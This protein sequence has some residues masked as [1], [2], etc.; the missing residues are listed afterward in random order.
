V[1]ADGFIGTDRNGSVGLGN[2]LS[3]VLILNSSGNA[4]IGSVVSSNGP[5]D[6]RG[7]VRIDGLG[8]VA[9]QLTGN[10]VGTNLAGSRSLDPN[11]GGVRPRDPEFPADGTPSAGERNTFDPRNDGVVIAGG[12]SGN[13]I[14]GLG[15]D[16]GNQISGNRI[17]VYVLQS[18]A[19]N[20]LVANR[21]GTDASGTS[22]V[23]NGDGVIV[24]NSSGN[25]IGGLDPAARNVIS[26]N[27]E[28]GVRLTSLAF[29][30][31][32]APASGNVVAGNYIGTNA[33][34]NAS[35]PNRQGVFVYGAADNRIGLGTFADP[36][37]GGNLLSG[38]FEVGIQILNADTINA[39]TVDTDAGPRILPNPAAE[40]A[41]TSGNIV[42]G[43]RIGSDATGT[44]RV[45]NYQGVFLSDAP[46][47]SVVDNLIGGN[48]QVG[49]NITAF[50][51]VNN[52]IGGNRIG[53][54][55]SGNIGP[56]ANGFGDPNGLGTGLLLNQV[57]DGANPIAST[58]DLRGNITAQTRIRPIADGPFVE[59]VI[60]IID[61]TTG[62]LT[63]VDVRINGY[64][65]RDA[66]I[67]LN[68]NNA[69]IE[70]IGLGP[71]SLASVSYDE[72]ARLLS[73]TP[74]SPLAPGLSFRLT[75][76]GQ[77]PG[78]LRSRPG[79]GIAP[80]F[81]DGTGN[82]RPGSNFVE[83][84]TVPPRAGTSS[85]ALIARAV[86]ALLDLD[87]LA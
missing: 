7:N 43:N 12:A 72:V 22:G 15:Q 37:G 40:G 13:S 60:P 86:D 3:G 54:D 78:G 77:R 26:G 5:S 23:S 70:P 44:D 19:G 66:A 53:P 21:I 29:E 74:S 9:N 38:N 46:G 50:N 81:L 28:T 71:V 16:E 69:I 20:V 83:V 11:L 41:V 82:G 52:F 68:P 39:R 65:D 27:L 47:N 84:V 49:L 67:T 80:A 42:A 76:I 17:G 48:V 18:S 36:N 58:N 31:P 4:L 61:P 6:R 51:A 57:V 2:G 14:G 79:P 10:R 24:L 56:L 87:E 33:E 75:L 32:R 85:A 35:V 34:G 55:V 30:G 73:I 1:V 45:P 8:S 63:R 64:L 25:T 62:M 59:G